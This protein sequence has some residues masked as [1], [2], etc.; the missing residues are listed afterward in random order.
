MLRHPF[1]KIPAFDGPSRLASA[2]QAPVMLRARHAENPDAARFRSTRNG[3]GQR[4][5]SANHNTISGSDATAIDLFRKNDATFYDE[6]NRRLAAFFRLTA[7]D[8]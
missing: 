4:G 2:T 1:S 3:I 5:K 6:R 8:K 7:S